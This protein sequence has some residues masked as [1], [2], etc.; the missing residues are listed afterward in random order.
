MC[1]IAGLFH[2]ET[3]K[4]V[5]PARVQLMTDVQ[6]HRGPDGSGIWTAPG[7]GLGHRRLSIIDVAGSPQPMATADGAVTITYNGEVYNFAE[8]RTEL[9]AL[10][11]QFR[12]A[13][14]TEVIL[15]GYR[16][17]GVNM[18]P[19]LN[20]MFAVAIHDAR[21]Q[22]LLLVRD[23]LGVKPLHY[24]ALADGSVAFSSE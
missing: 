11:H 22:S 8:I 4:P 13:G 19:R 10:G 14:D 16:Q 17:W 9:E 7:I 23:R 12:T 1:G 6:T 20:G 3:P 24:V 18:L 15:I 2:L 21:D 5:D